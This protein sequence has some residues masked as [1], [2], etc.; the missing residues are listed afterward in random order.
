MNNKSLLAI[1]CLALSLAATPTPAGEDSKGEYLGSRFEFSVGAFR[2]DLKTQIRL[3][4]LS[5]AIGTEV[6]FEETL[7]LAESESLPIVGAFYRFNRRH[8]IE[9]TF[10]DLSRSSD[11]ST[12]VE[13]RF[14]DVVFPIDTNVR[15][16]FDT[17]V[18]ALGY[19][20]SVIHDNKK[21]F[22]LS[23][24]LNVQDIRAGI[25]SNEGVEAEE[26][27][28]TAPLPTFGV[29]GGYRILPK[30]VFDGNV[31]VFGLEVEGVKGSI[32]NARASIFHQT[33]KHVGFGFGWNFFD[34]D[35]ETKD[36]EFLGKIIYQYSGPT[37]YVATYF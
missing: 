25:S 37:F 18:I 31:G 12:T 16:F 14:G 11:A 34:V 21:E 30:L 8:R 3:D 13:I 35:V 20:F 1:P 7:G 9:L 5:G 26:G 36:E 27:D 4:A 15:T 28:V 19:G 2:P 32:V 24:G 10:F 17:R 22:G 23:F 6:S 29:F 33:F